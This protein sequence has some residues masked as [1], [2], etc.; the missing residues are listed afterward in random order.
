[1]MRVGVAMHVT[2]TA[3]SLPPLN[4]VSVLDCCAENVDDASGMKSDVNEVGVE[5]SDCPIMPLEP[6]ALI[7]AL[8]SP[9]ALLVYTLKG[10]V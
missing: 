1:M 3:A 4:T 9:E 10:K 8:L 6:S 5:G 2:I 7:E